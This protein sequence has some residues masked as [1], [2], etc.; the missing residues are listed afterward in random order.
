VIKISSGGETWKERVWRGRQ[1]L[2]VE[3]KPSMGDDYPVVLRQVKAKAKRTW[4]RT[5]AVPWFVAYES[6]NT[7]TVTLKQVEAMLAPIRLVCVAGM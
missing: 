3:I 4:P 6:F 1:G 5:E 7:T 2:Y